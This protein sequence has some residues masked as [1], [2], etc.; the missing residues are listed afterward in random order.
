MIDPSDA[1]GWSQCPMWLTMKRE[2]PHAHTDAA[3]EGTVASWVARELAEGRKVVLGQQHPCGM[4]VTQEMLDGG[5]LYAEEVA[6]MT[7]PCFEEILH[8]PQIHDE[9]RGTPD[10]WGLSTV[11]GNVTVIDY[12]FG[13]RFVDEFENLQLISYALGVLNRARLVGQLSAGQ[14]DQTVVFDLT[15]VQPQCYQGG[16]PVRTWTVEGAHLRGFANILSAAAHDATQ[17]DP[18]SRTN[19]ECG[20]CA[21]RHACAALQ[22]ASYE[23]AEIAMQS[24]PAELPPEAASLELAM[25]QTASDRLAARV[26]GLTQVVIANLN[27]G[28]PAPHHEMRRGSG[29][30]QWEI[31]DEEVIAFGQSVG[32]SLDK[33][34]VI[35]P[36]QAVK[37]GMAQELVDALSAR[38][39]GAS[40]LERHNKSYARRAFGP[41]AGGV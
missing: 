8:I 15:I 1:K 19:S 5:E 32:V 23:S 7:S 39:P 29:R 14:L 3:L 34:G 10:V 31:P 40:K 30:V 33:P 16:S 22:Q 24:A 36:L 41:T 35:T 11:T 37:K 38:I 27:S 2:F 6:K 28:L 9:C 25:L 17:S 4:G 13:H 12:K 18:R 26:D 20:F 21:G